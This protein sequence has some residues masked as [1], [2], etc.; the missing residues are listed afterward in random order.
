MVATLVLTALAARRIE[1]PYAWIPASA[2]FAAGA[3]ML[4]PVSVTRYDAVVALSLA[5]AAFSFGRR[6]LAY[7]SLGFGAA[8]KLVPALATLPLAIF[9]R[10]AAVV[11]MQNA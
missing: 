3:M 1:G 6:Y 10:G 4:Y 2:T 9:R 7:A 8:A 11:V 5:V